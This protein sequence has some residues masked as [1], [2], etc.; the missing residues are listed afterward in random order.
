MCLEVGVIL[1]SFTK[2]DNF[3]L[4]VIRFVYSS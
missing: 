3:H 2:H 1:T 4:L